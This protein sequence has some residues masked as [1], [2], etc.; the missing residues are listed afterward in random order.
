MIVVMISL[1]TKGI[2]LLANVPWALLSFE[3]IFKEVHMF[4]FQIIVHCQSQAVR[5]WFL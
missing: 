3:K 4:V 2:L 5:R 1:A